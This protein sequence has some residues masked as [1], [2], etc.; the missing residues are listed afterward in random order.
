MNI[1]FDTTSS[2]TLRNLFM[3]LPS[4]PHPFC[5][6]FIPCTTSSTSSFKTHIVNCPLNNHLFFP[7]FPYQLNLK[8][9]E[10]VCVQLKITFQTP[11]KQEWPYD[12]V[13]AKEIKKEF[14]GYS[15]RQLFLETIS[16][17][18]LLGPLTLVL[19]FSSCLQPSVSVWKR[20]SHFTMLRMM[21]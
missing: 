6:S 9:I 19:S 20:C 8:S 21:K 13:L 12:L 2:L 5:F 15:S 1:Q 4:F 14:T 17:G 3:I 18:M 16:A 11:S 10:G 7:I